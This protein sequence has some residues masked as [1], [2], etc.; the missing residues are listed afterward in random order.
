MKP[1]EMVG[2]VLGHY[3]IVASLG[4]G[5]TATVFLAEDIHLRREVA[6][7]VFQ[8]ESGYTLEFLRRFEREAR[9]LAQLD[10]PNIL[11]VYDYGEQQHI[12]YLVMPRMAGGSLKDRL[13]RQRI[14]PPAETVRLIGPVLDALQYAHDRGLIHRDIKPGNLLS[15]IESRDGRQE[16]LLLSDFGLVKVLTAGQNAPLAADLTQQSAPTIAGTPDYIAP[17]QILGKATQASDIYS[18]GVV[19]YEMLTGERPFLAENYMGLLMKHLHE[20]PRPLRALNPRI[21]P[22]LEAVVLRAMEKEQEKRYQRPSDLHQALEWAISGKQPGIERRDLYATTP[23]V[24]A[25][26]SNPPTPIPGNANVVPNRQQTPGEQGGVTIPAHLT[27]RNTPVSYN[28]ASTPSNPSGQP[29]PER[30]YT[31]YPPIN[32]AVSTPRRLRPQQWV[33]LSL[34]AFVVIASLAGLFYVLNNGYIGTPQ[35]GAAAPATM[36]PGATVTTQAVPKTSTDCPAANT[37]R[38][39]ITATLVLG[40]HQ[41]IVYIVN[42]GTHDHPTAGTIKRREASTAVRGVEISRMPD[43][44]ISEAQVSQ[45]G[46]WV[47]FTAQVAGQVQMRMVRVDGQ[48]LQTLYCAPA[49]NSITNTQWSFNQQLVIFNVYPSSN[50]TPVKPTTYILDIM[51]GQLQPEL[52]PQASLAYFPVTWL[53]KTHVY[54]ITTSP[55]TGA[56]SQNIYILDIQKGGHQHDS[57]LQKIATGPCGSF[58]SS[59]DSKQLLIS[60]CKLAPATGAGP[61]TPIGPSTITIQ[62]ALGGQMKTFT[63]V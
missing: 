62:P 23:A 50:A 10:H 59:Y 60:T 42:E 27:V 58:D 4:Y 55:G 14:I 24:Q 2:Q 22:A 44:Y 36:V 54:M 38:A 25:Q 12:A 49:N 34:I 15:K 39:A 57:D 51:T 61:G 56:L 63:T 52:E 7:K 3:R 5:G 37:A 40:D 18:M 11:P 35:P 6:L 46:Q 48:G 45:D 32:Q 41:N 33:A 28:P 47:L 53:D 43:T 31:P 30:Q 29:T 8:P 13:H 1:E 17:E 19:L 16:R 9:V 21:P 20:Q 26:P